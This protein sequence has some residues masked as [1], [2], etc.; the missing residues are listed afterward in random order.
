MIESSAGSN[1]VRG[2]GWALRSMAQAATITPDDD[3]LRAQWVGVLDSNIAY[4]HQRYV[5]TANNPLG[6][7]HPYEDYYAGAPWDHAVWMDDFFTAAF[8]WMAEMRTHS[9]AQQ[10]KLDAFL[11]WKYRAVV[12]R[13]GSGAAGTYNYSA[14]IPIA[15]EGSP[16]WTNSSRGARPSARAFSG[17]LKSETLPS[18]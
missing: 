11:A 6:V 5:A 17:C 7:V 2:A 12:G 16:A 14:T 8:G 13:L 15:L 18:V 10:A 4:Y 3:A 1:T 9:Q